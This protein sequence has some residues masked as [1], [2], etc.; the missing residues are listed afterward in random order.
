MCVEIN[1]KSTELCVRDRSVMLRW[2]NFPH[3]SHSKLKQMWK[4][5]YKSILFTIL[6]N[7]FYYL[8][9]EV[10]KNQNVIRIK[11]VS[12]KGEKYSVSKVKIV[13]LI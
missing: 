8:I 5:A 6:S 11:V 3:L 10:K 4:D 7:N 9:H 1:T 13:A 12:I 2:Y